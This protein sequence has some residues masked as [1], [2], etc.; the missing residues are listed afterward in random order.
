[1]DRFRDFHRDYQYSH[2]DT[3]FDDKLELKLATEVADII[4]ELKM[5]NSLLVKQRIVIESLIEDLLRFGPYGLWRPALQDAVGHLNSVASNLGEIRTEASETYRL[6]FAPKAK[7][8]RLDC[9]NHCKLLEL[10]DL[11]SKTASLKEAR[12]S[13]TQGRTVML[14]TVVT[15]IFVSQLPDRARLILIA[16]LYSCHCL[17]SRLTLVRI[18]EKSQV[19]R[20]ITQPGISGK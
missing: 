4:D 1:M 14:F 7:N 18:S 16:Y 8:R 5:I 2:G 13:T 10:L 9:A 12:E 20:T 11:K 19:I 15:I 6:V 3:A 17:S